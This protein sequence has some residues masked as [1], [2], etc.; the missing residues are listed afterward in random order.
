[1]M[2]VPVIGLVQVG[3]QS[4]ADRYMYLPLV[5]VAILAA[6]GACAVIGRERS[7]ALWVASI[8]SLA[9]MWMLCSIQIRAWASSE[10]LW[11]H[12]L[13]ATGDG[14]GK[15]HHNLG[16]ALMEKGRRREAIEHF[17]KALQTGPVD[18][19]MMFSLADAYFRDGQVKAARQWF[20]NILQLQ[21]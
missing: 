13:K 20:A 4:M 2:L 17:T 9:A 12:A 5:G 21:D 16:Y 8:M 14:N 19:D 1:G 11:D 18:V 6:Y 7:P 3:S 15:A 10:T